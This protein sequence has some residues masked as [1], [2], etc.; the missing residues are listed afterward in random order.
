MF[1]K[2]KDYI[3][4]H[5]IIFIIYMNFTPLKVW[6]EHIPGGSEGKESASSPGFDLWVR[7]MPWRRKW[8]PTPVFLPGEFRGQRSLAG[9]SPL[10]HKESD[11]IEQQY[12]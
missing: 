7:K 12:Y 11:M 9:Y 8:Q 2:T 1:L 4:Y 6:T 5:G 10:A 3:R